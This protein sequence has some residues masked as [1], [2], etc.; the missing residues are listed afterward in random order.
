MRLQVGVACLMAVVMGSGGC[1][2]STYD[3]PERELRRLVETE[4]RDRG[5][6]LRVVQRLGEDPPP[7]DTPD[8]WVP[9][10]HE[11]GVV[12]YAGP[13]VVIH[14]SYDLYHRRLGPVS[15]HGHHPGPV[16]PPPSGGPSGPGGSGSS[17]GADIDGEQAL[18]ILAVV[19]LT[20]GTLIAALIE[21]ERYD[22]WVTVDPNHPVH[23]WGPHGPRVV[24]LAQLTAADL[25]DAPEAMIRLGEGRGAF[26]EGR[27]PLSREGLAWRMEVG[28]VGVP[29]V[30]G[31]T[32]AGLGA[33]AQF[34]YF[35]TQE[36][37]LLGT[38]TL[39]GGEEAWAGD[40][41]DFRMGAEL[42]WMPIQASVLNLGAYGHVGMSSASAAGGAI[43]RV[44]RTGLVAGGGLALELEI[45]TRV[46]V[47]VRAG[48]M[49]LVGDDSEAASL[50]TGGLSVY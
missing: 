29:L 35:A 17:G 47:G 9:Y 42:H 36:L 27:A 41:L 4:P 37:G 26:M 1:L 11:P 31:V 10:E 15:P 40:Y 50:V 49:T 45:V 14:P 25:A 13:Q 2:S 22:G 21:G 38:M 44:D 16:P 5:L 43:G 33:I 30:D 8:A 24:R 32:P 23:L 46:A 19:A 6:S 18:A 39:A 34:G 28:L 20:G 12:V 3:I 7:A 48:L